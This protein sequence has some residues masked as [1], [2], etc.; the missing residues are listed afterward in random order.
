ME[1]NHILSSLVPAF[2]GVYA[3]EQL[4]LVKNNTLAILNT[5]SSKGEGKHWCGVLISKDQAGEF[6][7]SLGHHLSRYHEHWHNYLLETCGKYKYNNVKL[8]K[9]WEKNCSAH[10]IAY[11]YYRYKGYSFEE[12]V[13]IVKNINLDLFLTELTKKC[14]E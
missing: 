4:K 2:S 1:I 10:V 13:N 14:C 11:V 7:D 8:Q 5:E 9:D 6:W 3:A 12:I